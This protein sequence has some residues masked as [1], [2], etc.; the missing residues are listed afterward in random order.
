MGSIQSPCRRS[1]R[2]RFPV[3]N[4]VHF[5][6]TKGGAL[7]VTGDTPSPK[8]PARADA[9]CTSGSNS[10]EGSLRYAKTLFRY[11]VSL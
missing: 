5:Q 3:R 4:V 8:A 9:S 7:W 6:L 10:S 1:V 11:R 2:T